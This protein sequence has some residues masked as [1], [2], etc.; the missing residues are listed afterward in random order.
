MATNGNGFIHWWRMNENRGRIH[1]CS[2]TPP[3]NPVAFRGPD[4]IDAALKADLKQRNIHTDRGCTSDGENVK[5][6]FRF[7][8]TAAGNTVAR[9]V[10][11]F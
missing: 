1:V 4:V 6:R 10:E 11:K 3:V 7:D 9:D 5:V 2:A 8:I